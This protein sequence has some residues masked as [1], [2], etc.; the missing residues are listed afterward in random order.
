M[1]LL[2]KKIIVLSVNIVNASNHKKCVSLR[3][4]TW[5]IQPIFI[6]LHPNEYRQ[7]LPY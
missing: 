6:N 7:E 3:N 4:Q 2:K 5:Q 1:E